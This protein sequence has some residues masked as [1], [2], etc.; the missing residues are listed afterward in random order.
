MNPYLSA[1]F[2]VTLIMNADGTALKPDVPFTVYGINCVVEGTDVTYRLNDLKN[3]GKEALCKLDYSAASVPNAN[4]IDESDIAEGFAGYLGQD[5]SKLKKDVNYKK[6]YSVTK[7][8]ALATYSELGVKTPYKGADKDEVTKF[9]QWT[10]LVAE[11][12]KIKE[13]E[14]GFIN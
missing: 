6:H 1:L 10:D 13:I 12:K 3:E 9:T 2:L 14:V 11:D 8:D 5:W 4:E 7:A